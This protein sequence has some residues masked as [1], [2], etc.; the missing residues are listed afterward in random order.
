[1]IESK[2]HKSDLA[3]ELANN[4]GHKSFPD[5][6]L[7]YY[8]RFTRIDEHL[9][10]EVH[11]HVNVGPTTREP[12][13]LTDHGPEHIATVIRRAGDLVMQ[14]ES[15]L[16]PYECYILLL[17]CH[18]HDMGNIFGRR[19]HEKKVH[20]IVFGLDHTLIGEDS[21]EKRVICDV[22]MAHGGYVDD[23]EIDKD[24]I[25]KLNYD[26][27]ATARLPDVKKLAAILRFADE[28]ADDKSRSNRFVENAMKEVHP[29]SEIFHAYASH[30][31][32]VE[33][34][35]DDHTVEVRFDVN[36]DAATTK[37][38]KHE[39]EVFLFDEILSRTLKM[40]REH[41]YCSR[42]MVPHVWIDRISVQVRICSENFAKILGDIRF[43]MAQNGYPGEPKALSEICPNL[44]GMNGSA[45]AQKISTLNAAEHT[46]YTPIVDLL[47]DNQTQAVNRV[48]SA[49]DS[50]KVSESSPRK[51]GILDK[52]KSKFGS[53]RDSGSTNV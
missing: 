43:E 20:E 39:D 5:T 9:N 32:P 25:G 24:T 4:P 27:S 21:P 44:V 23:E 49:V 6:N 10:N 33:V 1:M 34:K 17:A 16:S 29:G 8:D 46:A 50:L 52:I 51:P 18:S 38:R 15:V 28:L 22:A 26:R 3:M 40:H 42:F 36:V 7:D 45:L 19:D 41:V 13:W 47:V 12:M 37:F 48:T 14:P 53:G 11:P 2:N 31:Q 35:H 30:L